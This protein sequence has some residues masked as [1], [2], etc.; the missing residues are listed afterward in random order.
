MDVVGSDDGVVFWVLYCL[1][2]SLR[3]EYMCLFTKNTHGHSLHG[4]NS[5]IRDNHAHVS[6]R[7]AVLVHRRNY[8]DLARACRGWFRGLGNPRRTP[9]LPQRSSALKKVG[10]GLMTLLVGVSFAFPAFAFDPL[11]TW[12]HNFAWYNAALGVYQA[13]TPNCNAGN[14]GAGN[15]TNSGFIFRPQTQDVIADSF[16]VVGAFYRLSGQFVTSTSPLE[17]Y[18]QIQETGGHLRVVNP[19]G[20]GGDAVVNYLAS[21][22]PTS[23]TAFWSNG[24]STG[25]STTTFEAPTFPGADYRVIFEVGK[26]YQITFTPSPYPDTW[27]TYNDGTSFLVAW[28]EFTSGATSTALAAFPTY[29]WYGFQDRGLTTPCASPHALYEISNSTGNGAG[30]PV[31]AINGTRQDNGSNPVEVPTSTY[32]GTF[33]GTV[34]SVGFSSGSYTLPDGIYSGKF[35]NLFGDAADVFPLCFVSPWVAWLDVFQ[36][37]SQV[38]QTPVSMVISEP[39][40][41]GTTTIT[42]TDVDTVFADIG[43]RDILDLLFP[44]LEAMCWLS[45]GVIIFRDLFSTSNDDV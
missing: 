5:C 10:V 38:E 25:Y 32:D 19:N 29:F 6:R 22:V 34:G 2:K 24:Q 30:Y 35:S 42:L 17:V 27:P 26:T 41:A 11:D 21:R 23:T 13:T 16:D 14:T 7:G 43:L 1:F 8:S 31:W 3:L 33:S 12:H 9:L 39:F 18:A 45:L 37:F 20:L 40:G 4:C 36:G 44:F 15:E 28:S